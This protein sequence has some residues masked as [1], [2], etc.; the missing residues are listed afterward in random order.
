MHA[1]VAVALASALAFASSLSA[2]K[3]K[4]VRTDAGPVQGTVEN[5]ITIYKGIP[6]A[7]PPL[8]GLR[9]RA[10]KPASPWKEFCMPTNSRRPACKSR[11]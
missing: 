5:G 1:F 6:F 9:W 11:S 7:A 8:G 10:P 3:P 2:Q 4:P